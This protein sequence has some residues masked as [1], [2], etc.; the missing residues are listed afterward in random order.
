MSIVQFPSWTFGAIKQTARNVSG[1]LSPNELSDT[2]LAFYINNYYVYDLPRELKLEEQ[3][4]QYQFPLNPGVNTYTLPSIYTHTESPIYVNGIWCGYTEDPAVFYASTPNLIAEQQLGTTDGVTLIYTSPQIQS[5]NVLPVV[6]GVPN[7]VTIIDTVNTFTDDGQGNLTCSDPTNTGT[8]VYS[9][10]VITLTYAVAPPQGNNITA[11]YNYLTEG[12]PTFCLFYARTFTFY[13]TPDP[14]TAYQAR[15]KAYQQSVVYP[16]GVYST[17]PTALQ[18][19]FINNGDTPQKLEWGEL[20]AI[21]AAL[22]ILRDYGQDEKYQQTLFYYNK[23]RSKVMSDT[24]NQ[25]M[26]DRSPPRF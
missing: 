10:G 16:N 4:V 2:Q 12:W 15:I 3:Y 20:I 5:L 8:I 26:N 1:Q 19:Q 7:S 11:T 21:G 22:K 24:D 17:L 14:N 6:S 25:L 18:S 9:T 23:E 13:P